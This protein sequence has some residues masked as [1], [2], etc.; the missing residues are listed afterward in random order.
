MFIETGLLLIMVLY[1]VEVL[2]IDRVQQKTREQEASTFRVSL[3]WF[4][5]DIS[6]YTKKHFSA[7]KRA[8]HGF[9]KECG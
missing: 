1:S 2:D 3:G 6:K 9:C 7:S 5:S 8:F 4:L